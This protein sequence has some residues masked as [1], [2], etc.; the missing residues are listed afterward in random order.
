MLPGVLGSG[1]TVT[2]YAAELVPDPQV[3]VPDTV[4]LPPEAVLLNAMV[5]LLDVPVMVAPVPLYIQVYE[6]AFAT[7]ATE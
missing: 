6:V 2:A 4:K 7:V 5:T 1:F 3:L